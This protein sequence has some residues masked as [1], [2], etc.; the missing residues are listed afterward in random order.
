MCVVGS[1]T[2]RTRWVCDGGSLANER[3][4][5]HVGEEEEEEEDDET[6]DSQL[7]HDTGVDP[8]MMIESKQMDN[9][10]RTAMSECGRKRFAIVL[11]PLIVGVRRIWFHKRCEKHHLTHTRQ[12]PFHVFSSSYQER[13]DT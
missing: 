7:K 10:T 11:M 9:D 1:G 2:N 12:T 3:K 4:C 6:T 8:I 13:N 5:K